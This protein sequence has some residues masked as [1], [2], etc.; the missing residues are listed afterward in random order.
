MR[1]RS[2]PPARGRWYDRIV[3]P[4]PPGLVKPKAASLSMDVDRGRRYVLGCILCMLGTSVGVIVLYMAARGPDRLPIQ[5]VR[6]G[7]TVLISL[8]LYRG[9]PAARVLTVIGTSL[10]GV[11]AL[12]SG[13]LFL[14]VPYLGIAAVL[15]FSPSVSAY[16][17]YRQ[18]RKRA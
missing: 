5:L 14:A 7:I 17:N 12:F 16:F 8:F 2:Q 10:G 11:L 6:L 4:S 1:S 13:L 18:R 9:V 15:V 3:P